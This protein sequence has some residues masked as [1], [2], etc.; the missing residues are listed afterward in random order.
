MKKLYYNFMFNDKPFKK[1][2]I[3]GKKHNFGS[4]NTINFS[5]FRASNSTEI[6]KPTVN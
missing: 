1:I 2:F 6:K 5:P 4:H 3:S